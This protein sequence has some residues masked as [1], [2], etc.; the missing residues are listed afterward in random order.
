ML[1]KKYKLWSKK[2]TFLEN[3]NFGEKCKFGSTKKIILIKKIEIIQNSTFS[4]GLC[5]HAKSIFWNVFE[6]PKCTN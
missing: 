4:G 2:E 6:R 3:T 5:M 1:I